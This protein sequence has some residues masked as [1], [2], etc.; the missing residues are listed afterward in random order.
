MIH[1]S[2]VLQY[3]LLLLMTQKNPP[4]KLLFLQLYKYSWLSAWH[5]QGA[6]RHPKKCDMPPVRLSNVARTLVVVGKKKHKVVTSG[7]GSRSC[8]P[9]GC[10]RCTPSGPRADQPVDLWDH[11]E[12][13]LRCVRMAHCATAIKLSLRILIEGSLAAANFS[14]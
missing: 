6:T 12:E 7:F 4:K 1:Y 10:E 3:G 2:C 14:S 13:R 11:P 8:N 5:R 9:S